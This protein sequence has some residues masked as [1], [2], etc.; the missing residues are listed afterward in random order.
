VAGGKLGG[1]T[2][3]AFARTLDVNVVSSFGKSGYVMRARYF[4]PEALNVDLSGK[5]AI[6]TGAN[7]GVGYASCR[8]LA[9]L[10]A[11]VYM[12]CRSE[13]RGR[14]AIQAMGEE[15]VVSDN[16]QLEIVDIA[17]LDAIHDFANRF[18]EA[19]V[20]I[21]VNNAGIL[22][23]DYQTSADGIELTWATNIRGAYALTRSLLPKLEAAHGR[24]VMVSSGG[25]YL[26]KLD[27]DAVDRGPEGYDGVSA[28]A[29]SKRAMVAL[30][31]EWATALSD[32]GITINAMHPGWVDTPTL[33]ASLPRF[34]RLSKSILRNWSEGAD[35]IVWLAASE[36][37][38]SETGKLFF[39]RRAR[40]AHFV[41]WTW[42]S[43]KARQALKDLLA[44]Q[45]QRS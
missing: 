38:E 21:L 40:L 41:P 31:T 12:L 33:E 20:D 3:W 1:L 37:A 13:E 24:V 5:V 29:N 45:S 17:D 8:G 23:D 4:D 43:A 25:M 9:E 42:D 15:G 35:T 10:G 18:T 36:A 44:E 28:Y 30:A 6:V 39:D 32:R 2:D 14:A 27:L 19:R 22:V 16:L 34:Y 11:T 7:S 26:K